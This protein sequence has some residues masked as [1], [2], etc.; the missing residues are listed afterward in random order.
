MKKILLNLTKKEKFCFKRN[1]K[2]T[3]RMVGLLFVS[4]CVKIIC[5]KSPE[6]KAIVKLSMAIFIVTILIVLVTY[7]WNRK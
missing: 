1:L 5:D 2:Q 3:F 7:F 6:L 4:S